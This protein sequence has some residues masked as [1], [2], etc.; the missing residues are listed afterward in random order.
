MPPSPGNPRISAF[1]STCVPSGVSSRQEALWLWRPDL[2]LGPG[3]RSGKPTG[4]TGT[5]FSC[6]FLVEV[7]SVSM[8]LHPF[9]LYRTACLADVYPRK[10]YTAVETQSISIT[11]KASLLPSVACGPPP[12]PQA[13]T[14][15]LHVGG[16]GSWCGLS[17]GFT[18]RTFYGPLSSP[19][20]LACPPRQGTQ[21]PCTCCA[22]CPGALP[23]GGH[24][25]PAPRA[26]FECHS[27]REAC[28]TLSGR[29]PP[30]CHLPQALPY[31]LASR[32]H[33]PCR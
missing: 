11:P 4:H 9:K 18:L 13:T 32:A 27:T 29:W 14:D 12:L 17:G 7:Q 15:L 23:P 25:L 8:K 10:T 26:V 30:A 24:L 22:L 21:E 2:Q 31:S 1:C 3:S 19:A 6:V 20:S 28:P 33:W 16:S 5:F